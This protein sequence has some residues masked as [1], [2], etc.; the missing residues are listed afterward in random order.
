MK[1]NSDTRVSAMMHTEVSSAAQY[2]KLK[3]KNWIVYYYLLTLSKYND[4]EK[5]RY[6]Y[7]DNFNISQASKHL[8]IGRSTFYDSLDKLR[9]A[10]LIIPSHNSNY[11]TIPIKN[12]WAQI[13]K[14][15]LVQLLG[16]SKTQGIDLLR[17]YLFCKIIYE[18][19]G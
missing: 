13:S 19:Y 16:Y 4:E 1:D 3:E 5:H 12:G 6:V 7:R 15:L 2:K 8:G 10:G 11:Y 18:I 9:S 17:T 14:D